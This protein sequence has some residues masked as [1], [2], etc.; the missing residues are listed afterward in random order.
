MPGKG[1]MKEVQQGY[2]ISV[3][4]RH[5]QVTDGMKEHAIAR[6]A[7]L[8]RIGT[9]I[10]DIH[11][12]MDMQ[13][14]ANLVEILMKYGHTTI[15]SHAASEDMY[16]SIDQAVDK[17]EKQLKRYKSKL[18]DHHAKEHPIVDVPVSIWAVVEN[19]EEVGVEE[20]Q[21][22]LHKVISHETRPLKILTEDEALMKMELSNEAFM[23]YRSEKD[24]RLKVIYKR[25]D[26]TYGIIQPE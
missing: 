21:A 26:G 25:T 11:V 16:L 14:M 23:V 22:P 10:I 2:T 9:R 24:L 12:I 15:R 8:E 7:K 13:K 5:V 17:L 6:L 18:Q 3:T 1:T 20:L 4:G 19:P